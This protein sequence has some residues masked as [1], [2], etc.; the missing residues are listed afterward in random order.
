MEE[1]SDVA[2]NIVDEHSSWTV[3]KK[4]KKNKKF[5]NTFKWNKQKKK[6]FEQFGDPWYQEPYKFYHAAAHNTPVVVPVQPQQQLQQQPVLQ[7]QPV[8]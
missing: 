5:S 7:L 6:N 8:V 3:V 1:N 4:N 2:I